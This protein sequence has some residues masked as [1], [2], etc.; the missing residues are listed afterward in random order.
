MHSTQSDG[1]SMKEHIEAAEASPF[2]AFV[3]RMEEESDIVDK[4][5]NPPSLPA[6]AYDAWSYFLRLHATRQVGGLG[7]FSAISYQEILA[8]ITVTGTVMETWELELI[9]AFDREWMHIAAENS[10][11]EVKN[12]A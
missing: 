9:N 6:Q 1:S 4:Y 11:K 5:E 8:F 3:P 12:T 7:G 10:K 2:A